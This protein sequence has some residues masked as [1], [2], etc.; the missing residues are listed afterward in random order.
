MNNGVCG[1]FVVPLLYE[2]EE[3]VTPVPSSYAV[4]VFASGFVYFVFV[5]VVNG[6]CRQAP[7]CGAY[8]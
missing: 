4:L 8:R 6:I 5:R 2:L 3:L 7:E 1:L